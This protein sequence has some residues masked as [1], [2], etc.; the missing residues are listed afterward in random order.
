MEQIPFDP[1]RD[2]KRELKFDPRLADNPEARCA[3]VLLLDVSGSMA[4]V[5]SDAGKDLGYTIQS[6]GQ[7]YQA[8][9]GGV[10]KIDELNAGLTTFKEAL[11]ADSLAAKRVEVAIVTF[12]GKVQT[13]YDFTTADSFQPPV[14]TADG[15][16]PMGA[17]I[18]EAVELLRQ[19]KETYRTHGVGVFRPWIFLITDGGPTDE[20]KSAADLIKK[21]EAS[22]S[23]KFYAV[24][25]EEA[26]MDVLKE[27]SVE[28]PLKLKGIQF[29]KL[30]AWL[31]G[32]LTKISQSTPGD[33]IQ[34]PDP[35]AP[36]GW[37]LVES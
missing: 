23:F 11:A 33:K 20:W 34:L 9:S 4:E 14:L 36:S 30:F 8:V 13:A 29:R 3:C 10:T 35:T 24:G 15:N 26:N 19:R 28:P 27:L 7:T 37:A 31:S 2:P 18:R 32:S 25:V 17:A 22:K 16:T 12:G 1:K 6:D 21:G 5:V